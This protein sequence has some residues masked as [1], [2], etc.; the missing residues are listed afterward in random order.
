MD[1]ITQDTIQAIH[2]LRDKVISMGIQQQREEIRKVSPYTSTI[3]SV[4]GS[5]EEFTLY[6]SLGLQEAIVTRPAL[7]K[8]I[9]PDLWIASEG[10]TN[11][12]LM[13]EGNAPYA[14]DSAEGRIELHH[15]GQK[16]DNPFAELTFKEHM[17][18]F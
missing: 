4:I 13:E 11:Q 18:F 2:S 7:I 17:M 9:D 6:C 5:Y 3:N 14:Y 8:T 15:I 10:C 12:A 1:Y 16:H